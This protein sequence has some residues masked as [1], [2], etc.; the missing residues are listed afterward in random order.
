[1]L[2]YYPYRSTQLRQL[3][4]LPSDSDQYSVPR[5]VGLLAPSKFRYR[6]LEIGSSISPIE[7]KVPRQIRSMRSGRLVSSRNRIE[8]FELISIILNS[9]LPLL[10]IANISTPATLSPRA[11]VALTAIENAVSGS[12]GLSNTMVPP[13]LRFA[14]PCNDTICP[15]ANTSPAT[16]LSGSISAPAAIDMPFA[17]SSLSIWINN[18][19]TLLTPSPRNCGTSFLLL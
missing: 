12:C 18:S 19:D 10:S 5:A 9:D 4:S 6:I 16:S 1:M 11:L 13:A 17:L 7:A 2:R 15:A 8:G 3:N 14:R